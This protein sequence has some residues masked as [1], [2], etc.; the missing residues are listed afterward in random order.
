MHVGAAGVFRGL[1]VRKEDIDIVT[2]KHENRTHLLVYL[3]RLFVC[4]SR[5][6]TNQIQ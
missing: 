5:S 3:N 4:S 6:H 2:L 1:A